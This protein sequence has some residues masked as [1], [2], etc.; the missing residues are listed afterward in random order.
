MAFILSV[1][2]TEEELQ[3]TK[4]GNFLL[5]QKNFA[6]RTWWFLRVWWTLLCFFFTNFI[7][8]NFFPIFSAPEFFFI[9]SATLRINVQRC[10]FFTSK[11]KINMHDVH[12][13]QYIFVLLRTRKESFNWWIYFMV[14]M[15]LFYLIQFDFTRFFFWQ[16]FHSTSSCKRFWKDLINQLQIAAI[17]F[18]NNQ[19]RKMEQVVFAS[20]AFILL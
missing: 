20:S 1:F 3:H 14:A 13:C 8:F 9:S 16:F 4:T 5:K 10:T 18:R 19:F 11:L 2:Q 12:N 7:F 6:I 15:L 17:K